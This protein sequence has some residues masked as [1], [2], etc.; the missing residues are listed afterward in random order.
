VLKQEVIAFPSGRWTAATAI[1]AG[2]AWAIGMTPSTL[3]GF[4]EDHPGV[5]IAGA[6]VFAPILLNSIGVAQWWV[7][8]AHIAGAGWW[9]PANAV[10][11]LAGLPA[12]FIAMMLV[13]SD[14]GVGVRAA[15]AV[16]G[17]VTMGA[18]V[19]VITGFALSRLL[20]RTA[21]GASGDASS[22]SA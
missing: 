7:L 17:A 16:A 9:V 12:V 5:I 20:G 3:G 6:V 8:R 14:A 13:P 21:R 22:V 18:I 11:W 1:A 2:L 19:A 10:G 15:A 4:T